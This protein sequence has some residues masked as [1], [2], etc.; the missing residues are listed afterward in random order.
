MKGLLLKDFYTLTSQMRIFFLLIVIF[1]IMPGYSMTSFAVVYAG[2]IPFTALAYDERAKWDSLAAMMPYSP[3]QIV[4]AKYVLG[5]IAVAGAMLIALVA[6][7]A[8][9]LVS[10]A[11]LEPELLPFMLLMACVS[12]IFLSLSLPFMFKFGVEKGR[13]FFFILIGLVMGAVLIVGDKLAVSLDA[14]ETGMLTPALVALAVCL[15]LSLASMTLSTR[16][17]QRREL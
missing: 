5:Y 3:R 6:N 10:G 9:A 2:M 16:W 13:V 11:G 17:Y 14:T 4:A 1:A 12:M 7:L 15:L 8:S